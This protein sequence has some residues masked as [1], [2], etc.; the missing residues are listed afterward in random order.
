MLVTAEEKEASYSALEM[1]LKRCFAFVATSCWIS[2]RV[3]GGWRDLICLLDS[4]GFRGQ[5]LP[6]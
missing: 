1:R 4:L 5:P 2:L 6:W 3:G